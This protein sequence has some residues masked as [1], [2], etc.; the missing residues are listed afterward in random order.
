[1]EGGGRGFPLGDK[2]PGCGVK[3]GISVREGGLKAAAGHVKQADYIL[4]MAVKSGY[5]TE[6]QSLP[7]RAECGELLTALI[8]ADE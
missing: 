6:R 7:V 5:L 4:E 8:E 1:M 3:A 2:R